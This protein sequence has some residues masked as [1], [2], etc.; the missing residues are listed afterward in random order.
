MMS[1]IYLSDSDNDNSIVDHEWA[2]KVISAT[3]SPQENM[4]FSTIESR[5]N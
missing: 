1:Y 2:S 5:V 4:A 3:G